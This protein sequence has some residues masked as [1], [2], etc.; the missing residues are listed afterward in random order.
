MNLLAAVSHHAY[1]A[2]AGILFASACGLPLPVSVVLL[3]AGASAHGAGLNQFLVIPCGVFAATAGDTLLYLGGK[4]TGWWLLGLLCRVSINP[5]TCIFG[6]ANRFYRRGP[7]TLL[8]AKFVPGLSTV[9]APLS[10]SLNMP[11]SKFLSLDVL[12][13]AL[14]VSAW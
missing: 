1:G 9:A 11:A 4:S 6:S 7:N 12:G 10:G 3:V 2:T 5:E 14:Y 13:A 8:F